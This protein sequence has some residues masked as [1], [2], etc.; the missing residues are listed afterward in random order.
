MGKSKIVDL[1]ISRDGTYS[2]K[3]A[4]TRNIATSP[5]HKRTDKNK[6]K[7]VPHKDADE[8]LSGLD[9]GLDFVESIKVRALRVLSLW[10]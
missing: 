8:F 7:Y 2:T 9:A 5:T 3:D 1:E 6:P 10:E 4:K